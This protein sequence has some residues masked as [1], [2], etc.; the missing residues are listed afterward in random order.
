MDVQGK[1]GN[2]VLQFSIDDGETI[3]GRGEKQ[4]VL[5]GLRE[6]QQQAMDQLVED[7]QAIQ[8]KPTTVS[9]RTDQYVMS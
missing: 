7:Y 4:L 9:L 6:Y 8:G 5:S 3:I 1:R 2:V